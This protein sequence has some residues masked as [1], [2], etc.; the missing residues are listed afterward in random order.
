MSRAGPQ[1][2]GLLG[3]LF[4]CPAPAL[5]RGK[6]WLM[7]SFSCCDGA[8]RPQPLFLSLSICIPR[9][10]PEELCGAG[11]STLQPGRAGLVGLC[12]R[13]L[14]TLTDPAGHFQ[15]ARRGPA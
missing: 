14:G 1:R 2:Q 10:D 11:T 4:P 5:G 3:A 13:S 8:T 7:W 12:P 15:Q 6:P 9:W